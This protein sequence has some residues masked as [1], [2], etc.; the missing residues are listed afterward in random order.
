VLPVILRPPHPE[1]RYLTAGYNTSFRC[2]VDGSPRPTIQWIDPSNRAVS[3]FS[4]R[5]HI[6]KETFYIYNVK[7][8]DKGKWTCRVT[9]GNTVV[10]ATAEILD[11]YGKD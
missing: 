7:P 8:A 3:T 5:Y 10:S 1:K 9:Q 4:P 6:D 2:I 11:V